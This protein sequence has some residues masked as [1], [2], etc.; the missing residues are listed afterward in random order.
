M[1]YYAVEC[2][3]YRTLNCNILIR[4]KNLFEVFDELTC[5]QTEI[6]L[7]YYF[8]DMTDVKIARSLHK[9]RRSINSKSSQTLD[10]IRTYLKKL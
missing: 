7:L 4:N 8:S 3:K 6:I 10:Q 2:N 5:E 9:S 1:Y